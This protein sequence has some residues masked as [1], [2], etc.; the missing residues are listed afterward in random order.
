MPYI[1]HIKHI[2]NKKNL[3]KYEMKP[4]SCFKHACIRRDK[5]LRIMG[6][7]L[8]KSFYA[9]DK[10]IYYLTIKVLLD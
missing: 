5:P 3:L 10:N 8:T 9:Y 1:E 2:T 4:Q 6:S 7:V